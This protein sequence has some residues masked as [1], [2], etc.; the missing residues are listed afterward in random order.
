[1]DI[2]IYTTPEK[3]LHK[4]GKLKDDDDYSEDGYYYW[5]LTNM[6]K[7]I[8]E[9]EKIYFATKGFIRGYFIVDELDINEGIIF[10]CKTWKDIKLIIPCT[11]F[12]GFKYANKVEELKDGK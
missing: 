4:Q 11:H 1:M 9:G 5:Y 6:P 7:E 3:L 12:Q 10:D 2:I 8:E